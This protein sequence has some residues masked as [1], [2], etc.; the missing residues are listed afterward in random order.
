MVFLRL[1]GTV[2]RVGTRTG[3]FS[4]VFIKFQF[5]CISWLAFGCLLCVLLWVRKR[6]FMTNGRIVIS[7]NIRQMKSLIIA[8]LRKEDHYN[9][10][11]IGSTHS[12]STFLQKEPN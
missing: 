9:F 4:S 3:N 10:H 8:L 1:V 5:L 7:G 12:G 2:G 11:A 6:C